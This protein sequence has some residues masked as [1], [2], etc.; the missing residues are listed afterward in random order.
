MYIL[1]TVLTLAFLG[2][3]VLFYLYIS[4]KRKL[5]EYK[6]AIWILTGRLKRNCKFADKND[7]PKVTNYIKE[8]FEIMLVYIPDSEKE[9]LKTLFYAEK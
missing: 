3:G 6:T 4:A 7:A 2:I 1:Y 9:E 5:S 8:T